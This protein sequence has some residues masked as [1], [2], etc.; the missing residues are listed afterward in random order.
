MVCSSKTKDPFLASCIR[1]IWLI[2]VSF[3]KHKYIKHI[4]GKKMQ[5]QTYCPERTPM[6]PKVSAN[7]LASLRSMAKFYNIEH[8]DLSHIAVSRF[9]R[10]ITINSRFRPTPSGVFNIHTLYKISLA[11]DSLLNAILFRAIF[12]TAFFLHFSE[13]LMY[14][15]L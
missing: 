7:Y 10:S 8:S 2:S 11:C 4:P 13:C 14:Q 1:N 3:D 15:D 9:L 5:F 6:S 12:L